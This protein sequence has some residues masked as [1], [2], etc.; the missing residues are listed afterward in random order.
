MIELKTDK[1]MR[2]TRQLFKDFA[3]EKEKLHDKPTN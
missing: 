3:K 2:T 1:P